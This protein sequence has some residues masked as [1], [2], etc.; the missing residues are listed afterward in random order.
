MRAGAV[1][2]SQTFNINKVITKY[3]FHRIE[4]FI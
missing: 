1:I 2:T 3:Y 4:K